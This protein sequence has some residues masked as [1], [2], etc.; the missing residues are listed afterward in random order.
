MTRQLMSHHRQSLWHIEQDD[1]QNFLQIKDFWSTFAI[2]YKKRAIFKL[3]FKCPPQLSIPPLISAIL[4]I[5]DS[6]G[7]QSKVH[8]FISAEI[9]EKVSYWITFWKY[10]TIFWNLDS[11]NPARNWIW[12]WRNPTAS[13]SFAKVIRWDNE[14]AMNIIRKKFVEE[15][16]TDKSVH[17]VELVAFSKLKAFIDWRGMFSV[18]LTSS[19]AFRRES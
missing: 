9:P 15:P 13:R 18:E 16:Y 11:G 10:K 4:G 1:R 7:L 12:L 6:S 14:N 8:C 3:V 5:I 19:D 17:W 2:I